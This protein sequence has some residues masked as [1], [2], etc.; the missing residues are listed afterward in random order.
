MESIFKSLSKEHNSVKNNPDEAVAAKRELLEEI[1]E[2]VNSLSWLSRTKT[3]DKVRFFIKSGYDYEALCKEFGIT[4]E[5]A[6]NAIK[7][8]SKQLKAK[9]GRNTVQLIRFGYI[10]EARVAFYVGIAKISRDNLF[11]SD[12]NG[13]LPESK[14]SAIYTLQDCI[15]ELALLRKMSLAYLS[16]YAEKVDR[17]KLAYLLSLI[18]GD[19]RKATWLRPYIINMIQGYTKLE[20]LLA[21]EEI[22]KKEKYLY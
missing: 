15:A 2:Y 14:Y 21:M 19:S 4:Y 17:S 20:D 5:S 11:V 6:K 10:E 13:I 8:A 18:E 22:I 16:K 12:L 3:K 7:W 1:V 9:I